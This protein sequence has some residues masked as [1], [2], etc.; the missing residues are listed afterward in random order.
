M[1]STAIKEW[2]WLEENPVSKIQ[3]PPENPA[4][5][6]LLT[7]D[8]KDR[9][10]EACRASKSQF[11]VPVMTIALL[12]GMRSGEILNLRWKDVDFTQNTIT[13]HRTKNGDSRIVP[14]TAAVAEIFQKSPNY[15]GQQDTL[16]FKSPYKDGPISIRKS[17]CGA[18]KRANIEDFTFHDLRRAAGS[19]LAMDGATLGE[20]MA[21][22]GHK[23][24]QM[25]YR[26]TR[27]Y[28]EHLHKI[29]EKTSQNLLQN[30]GN[31]QDQS[32]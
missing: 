27:Y 3:K 32:A 28:Q 23:T 4:R 29:M 6:R 11:L 8:E 26:Y 14:L 7:V 19:Y 24:P 5:T 18:L 16:I 13:L 21:I 15:P 17:Y 31:K 30:T 2:G 10:L 20:L 12:T 25:T 22:L 1:L 9:L